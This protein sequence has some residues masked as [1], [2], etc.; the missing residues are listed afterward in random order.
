M[1]I[2]QKSNQSFTDFISKTPAQ[3]ALDATNQTPKEM[4][5][6]F[7]LSRHSVQEN[8]RPE[9][10]SLIEIFRSHRTLFTN[11][12][13]RELDHGLTTATHLL[14]RNMPL[15]QILDS[16]F[17]PEVSSL[18]KKEYAALPNP[19][20]SGVSAQIEKFRQSQQGAST[21]VN[22]ATPNTPSI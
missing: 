12:T 13:A 5:F 11:L 18:L 21:K 17:S 14:E 9:V 20:S 4:A 15:N 19:E 16:A 10:K 2:P 3:V 8:V 22:P 7:H 1:G 6:A